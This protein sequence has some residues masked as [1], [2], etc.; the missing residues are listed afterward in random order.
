MMSKF[1]GLYRRTY[2]EERDFI[3]AGGFMSACRTKTSSRSGI[4]AGISAL[5]II[6]PLLPPIFRALA[7]LHTQRA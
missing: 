2:S 6:S 1:E 7:I 4:Q 3:D 5:P